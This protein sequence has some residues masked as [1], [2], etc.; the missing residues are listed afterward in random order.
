ME[1][2]KVFFSIFFINP[3]GAEALLDK[4]G[5]VIFLKKFPLLMAK[6]LLLYRPIHT[7][8][9]NLHGKSLHVK[10]LSIPHEGIGRERGGSKK[11]IKQRKNTKKK[12]DYNLINQP[13]KESQIF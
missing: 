11:Q 12:V 2:E 7:Y 4:H 9:N 13:S 8:I 3:Q 1:M 10:C 5:V 6:W